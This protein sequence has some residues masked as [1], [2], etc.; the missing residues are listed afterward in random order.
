MQKETKETNIQTL[1]EDFILKKTDKSFSDLFNRLK[2]GVSNHC[3]LILKDMELAEDAFLNTMSKIWLKID[4]YD[5]G[6]GNFSTWCYNIARNES[7]LL[8]KSRKRLIAHEDGDL[9][10]LSSKNTIGDIGGFYTIEDDPAYGFFNEENT[11]DS[12]YESVL[13]EIRSLPE[14]YR[15]IMIDREINGM[16]YK[17]IAEKYG[18]KKRSIATRIRRARGRIRKKMDGKH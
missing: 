15:D 11:I 9:E 7:L 10:Y 18:I 3:F 14:T 17:D 2:P 13:D 16:K 1:A 8:M 4:Q 6:R 12:V 5:M